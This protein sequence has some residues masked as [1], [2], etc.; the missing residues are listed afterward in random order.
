[1]NNRS[2]VDASI[3]LHR[4]LQSSQGSRNGAQG[5]SA[6]LAFEGL[7]RLILTALIH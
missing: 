1:M 2:I 4:P 6:A 5:V 3:I 7:R